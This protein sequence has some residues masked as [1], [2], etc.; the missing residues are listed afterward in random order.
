MSPTP[1]AKVRELEE[2]VRALGRINQNLSEQIAYLSDLY[3][4]TDAEKR[5]LDRRYLVVRPVALVK[6]LLFLYE[7]RRERIRLERGLR[8]RS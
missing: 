4:T 3:M 1:E 5:R 7:K 2:K 8:D 6:K